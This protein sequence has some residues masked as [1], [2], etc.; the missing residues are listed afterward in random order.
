[1]LTIG[2]DLHSIGY[3]AGNKRAIE[4]R[5]RQ[6]HLRIGNEADHQSDRFPL[7]FLSETSTTLIQQH[8]LI[9]TTYSTTSKIAPT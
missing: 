5:G 6:L 8:F 9:T 2:L 3:G 7:V 1:M 4:L